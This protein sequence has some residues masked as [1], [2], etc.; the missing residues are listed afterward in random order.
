MKRT[1][2]KS[3]S[4]E[5]VMGVTA[6]YFHNNESSDKEVE[7]R[8]DYQRI[9]GEVFSECGVYISA[10]IT[11]GDV[12]YHTDWGCPVGGEKIFVIRGERN[13]LFVEDKDKNKYKEAVEQ[14]TE[15]LMNKYQQ[16][17]CS[18]TWKEVTFSYFQSQE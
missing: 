1:E 6:G 15:K 8:A 11:S 5:I 7:F 2:M 14:I 12:V 13:P 10:V 17:T 9:A 18:L 4:F 16:S 3:E